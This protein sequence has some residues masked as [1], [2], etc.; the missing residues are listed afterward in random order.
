MLSYKIPYKFVYIRYTNGSSYLIKYN[1]IIVHNNVA[2]NIKDIKKII[3]HIMMQTLKV[4]SNMPLREILFLSRYQ[5][6][7]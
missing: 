2:K 1:N 5:V 4:D 6:L 3:P 7:T